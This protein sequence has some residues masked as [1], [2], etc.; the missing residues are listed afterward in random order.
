MLAAGR[1]IPRSAE[2][3]D[4]TAS[5]T[6]T[7]ILEGEADVLYADPGKEVETVLATH[8]PGHFSA[9]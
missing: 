9:N 6:L 5:P 3:C 2:P 7:D 1:G 8:G 4:S